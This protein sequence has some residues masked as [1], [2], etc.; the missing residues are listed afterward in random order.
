MNLKNKTFRSIHYKAKK[1]QKDVRLYFCLKEIDILVLQINL[2][3][4]LTMGKNL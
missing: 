2:T 1:F 3:T 4:E